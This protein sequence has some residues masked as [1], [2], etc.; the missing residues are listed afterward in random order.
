MGRAGSRCHLESGELMED[1]ALPSIKWF[2][3]R[4]YIVLTLLYPF[5]SSHVLSKTGTWKAL[6]YCSYLMIWTFNSLFLELCFLFQEDVLQSF[7]HPSLP[8]LFSICFL[9]YLDFTGLIWQFLILWQGREVVWKFRCISTSWCKLGFL[10]YAVAFELPS[11]MLLF[12]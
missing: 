1:I 12:L 7:S 5:L 4:Y 10:F 8:D 3:Q 6:V 9:Q 2:L 11:I